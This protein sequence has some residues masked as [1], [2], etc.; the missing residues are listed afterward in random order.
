MDFEM[1]KDRGPRGRKWL[2]RERAAYFQLVQQGD[3]SRE[4]CR[5]VGIDRR[6]GKKRW[7]PSTYCPARAM[8]EDMGFEFARGPQHA[9]QRSVRVFTENQ[10]RSALGRSG[11]PDDLRM[12]AD[13]GERNE[14]CNCRVGHRPPSRFPSLFAGQRG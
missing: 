2:T 3:S 4:A 13:R 7:G 8:A 6:T 5:I 11:R 10:E 9:F 12:P 1:R 14:N